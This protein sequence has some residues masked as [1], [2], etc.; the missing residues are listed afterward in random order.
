MLSVK[1]IITTASYH[2]IL[3]ISNDILCYL[4]SN[5]G[6]VVTLKVHDMRGMNLGSN[7][8]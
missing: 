4:I 6:P 8:K 5:K 3:S 2:L 1:L 7:Q